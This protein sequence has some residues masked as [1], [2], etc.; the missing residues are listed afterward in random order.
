[1]DRSS[2]SQAMQV[3]DHNGLGYPV[4]PA[5]SEH[6]RPRTLQRHHTIQ[7]SD[8][9]YVGLQ[10]PCP[11]GRRERAGTCGVSRR[12]AASCS[13]GLLALK[14]RGDASLS[15]SSQCNTTFSRGLHRVPLGSGLSPGLC[16]AS[17][18]FAAWSFCWNSRGCP[19]PGWATGG[20]AHTKPGFGLCSAAK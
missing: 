3:P 17:R 4:R 9:A 13:A 1:M 2:P 11:A 20:S 7:N 8:D 5:S 19:R 6:P 10:T 14:S 16:A 12:L 15:T 18:L